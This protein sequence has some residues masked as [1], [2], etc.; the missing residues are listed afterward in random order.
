MPAVT[1]NS[2]K[3]AVQGDLRHNFYKISGATG[4]TLVSGLLNIKQ[5][6]WDPGVI[7]AAVATPGA[8]HT[9]SIA[10]TST[11]AYTNATVQLIGN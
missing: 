2:A 8:T 6:I 10:F 1:V 3:Y 7:T 11:G 4:D 5:I 9:N